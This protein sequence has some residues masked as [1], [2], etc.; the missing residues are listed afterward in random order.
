[1][2]WQ[3]MIASCH[4]RSGNYHKAY[5]IYKAVHNKFPSNTDVLKFLVRLAT[6]LG[7]AE[8]KVGLSHPNLTQDKLIS[9]YRRRK[10]FNSG[11]I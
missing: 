1:M 3:L 10:N 2:K 4:R 8:A 11:S 9:T 7:M 6:D 5:E